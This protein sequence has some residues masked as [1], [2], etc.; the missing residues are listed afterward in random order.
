MEQSNNKKRDIA[1]VFAGGISGA[2]S[3]AVGGYVSAKEL[4]DMELINN[5]EV[6]NKTHDNENIDLVENLEVKPSQSK[7]VDLK[8][9]ESSKDNV[10]VINNDEHITDDSDSVQINIQL[11]YNEVYVDSNAE[12]VEDVEVVE[13][14]LVTKDTDELMIV[15]L[16]PE[17]IVVELDKQQC[18]NCN[19]QPI[20]I[21]ESISV[22]IPYSGPEDTFV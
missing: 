1:S 19:T 11:S 17:V 12:F 5:E 15:D 3:G 21:N 10:P 18:E 6:V 16:N 13:D 22:E 8:S 9:G 20:Y 4:D 7:I 14:D 2:I